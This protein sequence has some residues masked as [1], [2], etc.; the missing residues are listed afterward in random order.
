MQI[1]FLCKLLLAEARFS[2][3]LANV[4]ADLLADLANGWH[5]LLA[6]NPLSQ[7]PQSDGFYFIVALFSWGPH[8]SRIVIVMNAR[9]GGQNNQGT[10]WRKGMGITV[11]ALKDKIGWVTLF[12][13]AAFTTCL[14]I[15]FAVAQVRLSDTSIPATNSIQFRVTAPDTN[16]PFRILFSS[17]LSPEASNWNNYATGAPGQTLFNLTLPTNRAGYFRVMTIGGGV[18]TPATALPGLPF[19]NSPL[20]ATADA[21]WEQITNS[22]YPTLYAGTNNDSKT[23]QGVFIPNTNGAKLAI[24]TDDNSRVTVDGD[25]S[26]GTQGGQSSLENRG[27]SFRDISSSGGDFLAGKPYCV[28]VEYG[29]GTQSGGDRDGVTL[30]AYNGGGGVNTGPLFRDRNAV[31]VGRTITL[32]GDCG[33]PAYHW[34]ISDTNIAMLSTLTG[35]TTVVT[36]KQSGTVTITISDDDGRSAGYPFYVVQPGITPAAWV[37]CVGITNT[38]IVTNAPGYGPVSWNP[39][40]VLSGNTRTNRVVFG[41][42]GSFTVTATYGGCDVQATVT[43]V[44]VN[45]LTADSTD[46][47]RSGTV[48]YTATTTPAGYESYL[49][50]GGEAAAGGGAKRTNSYSTPG[51]HLV[52]VSCDTSGKLFTNIVYAVNVIPSTQTLLADATA[53]AAYSLTNSYG[54]ASWSVSPSGPSISG[55]PGASVSISPGSVGTNFAVTATSAVL[56]SC[57][58]TAALQVVQV[59]FSTNAL[60][61]CEGSSGMVTMRVTPSSYAGQITLDTVTNQ[62]TGG[63]NTN[64]G[65][66]ID[67]TGTNVTVTGTTAGTG[68]LRARLGDSVYIGPTIKIARISFSTNDWYVKSG[69][70]STFGLSVLPSDASINCT[71]A[72]PAIATATIS[73]TNVTVTGV[74]PGTT[75]IFAQAG[76]NQSC[77][78]KSVTVVRVQFSTNSVAL[79]SG[80]SISV[81]VII[82]PPGAPVSFKA[83]NSNIASVSVIGTNATITA[84][85]VGSTAVSAKIGSLELDFLTA[86]V[87]YVGFPTNVYVTRGGTVSVPVIIS[88]QLFA[89]QI[90]FVSQNTNIATATGSGNPPRANVTGR[91][92]GTTQIVAQMG[93]S[94]MCATI[95]VSVV[96]LASVEWVQLVS[97]L[98]TNPNPG[99]G[100]RIFPDFSSPTNFAPQN[101]VQIKATLSAPLQGVPIFFKSFDVD[102]PSTNLVIDPNGVRGGDNN[103]AN[104]NGFFVE[105][106]AM[107]DSNGVAFVEFVLSMQPGNNFRVGMS[108]AQSDLDQLTDDSVPSGNSAPTNTPAKFTDMLTVWRRLWIERDSMTAV[109]SNSFTAR[110]IGV[111]RN[112]TSSGAVFDRVQLDDFL[113]DDNDVFEGGTL[114]IPALGKTLLIYGNSDNFVAADTV[115]V[116]AGSFTTTE[117]AL[118]GGTQPTAILHDDDNDSLLPHLPSGGALITSAF[119][120]AYIL[121]IYADAYNVRTTIP[122]QLNL[123][124]LGVRNDTDDAQDLSSSP[125]CWITLVVSCFQHTKGEDGDPDGD[126]PLPAYTI[127]SDNT[128]AYGASPPLFTI[129]PIGIGIGAL[130]QSAIFLETIDDEFR[131]VG[132]GAS[133]DEVHTVVHEIGHTAGVNGLGHQRS[134]IMLD[135]APKEET[136]FDPIS[137]RH[138]RT[139]TIW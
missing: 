109:T 42:G 14:G 8:L 75:Q 58:G 73:G 133:T 44:A 90:R 27:N 91:T 65:V 16:A 2:A 1:R 137:I 116:P 70:S 33:T 46:L 54:L 50:W 25:S 28:K 53:P 92:N 31:C 95:P 56:S 86:W 12:M 74:A 124:A 96:D 21:L 18:F 123:S 125:D 13:G 120:D 112:I 47:C 43:A 119:A 72:N 105:T 57:V 115:D 63:T 126:S 37:T 122:F 35:S 87:I 39:S 62:V 10:P 114:S 48:I 99:G 93:T 106:S 130:N 7:Q 135:G 17:Q 45:T 127:S 88:P 15:S 69:G 40:G 82:E 68:W 4:F 64:A 78:V 59:R 103:G 32:T 3:K 55:S 111:T 108:V 67:G 76:T 79:C 38:F 5:S 29:N 61:L 101:R 136:N 121:P 128:F 77:A 9:G 110:A 6:N 41:S 113:P 11:K 118:I 36:G 51:P 138:F 22:G 100:L 26:S 52:S 49:S 107:T 98:D 80:N 84:K 129:Q 117:V 102:D 89:S 85:T 19:T 30:Y 71:S 66:S 131:K 24:H 23:F 134:G 34:A 81:G 20:V 139:I 132:T 104:G 83:G 94:Q 97:P 60:T